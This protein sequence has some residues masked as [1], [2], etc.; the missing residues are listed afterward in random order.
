MKPCFFEVTEGDDGWVSAAVLVTDATTRPLEFRVTD[1]VH[2]D[3]VQRVLYGEMF[4][5]HLYGTVLAAPLLEA[6]R[7]KPDVLLVRDQR[8]LALHGE[9]ELPVLWIGR[10]EN[11]GGVV[12][13]FRGDEAPLHEL[14]SKLGEAVRGKDLLEPFAR[15]AAALERIRTDELRARA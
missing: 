7:E 6:L 9:S 1:A 4:E 13:G 11:D 10:D 15:I 5:G 2:T 8:L 3:D 14:R 12:V